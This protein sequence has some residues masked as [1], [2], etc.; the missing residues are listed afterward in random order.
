MSKSIFAIVQGNV[1]KEI[2]A[3]EKQIKLDFLEFLNT[4]LEKML[5]K[6]ECW[7]VAERRFKLPKGESH[8]EWEKTAEE[9]GFKADYEF[10]RYY[11]DTITLKPTTAESEATKLI[12]RHNKKVE[13]TQKEEQKKKEA[14]KIASRRAADKVVRELLGKLRSGDYELKEYG[15]NVV[16]IKVT[17]EKISFEGLDV[18]CFKAF[19]GDI[20]RTYKFRDIVFGGTSNNYF[21]IHVKRPGA[22]ETAE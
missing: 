22:E 8:F 15:E 19:V 4:E 2:R 14:I 18:D 17:Y 3:K 6:K 21:E 5:E 12:V 7:Y 1:E 20:L 11:G 10:D 9:M 13:K 16:T